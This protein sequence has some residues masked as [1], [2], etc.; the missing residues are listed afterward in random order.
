M[1]TIGD[2]ISHDFIE[3]GLNET[4]AEVQEKVGA[5]YGVV[6]D[7]DNRPVTIIVSADLANLD[8]ERPLAEGVGQVP[9]GIIAAITDTMEA[10]V[11]RPAFAAFALGVRGAI[12]YEDEQVAGV[13][14]DETITRY[15]QDE[16]EP[17]AEI[18]G[19]PADTRLGGNITDKPLIMYCD[20]F[21]HRNELDYYNRHKPP[22]C[23]VK[24]PNPHPIRRKK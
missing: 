5:G 21:N 3:L 12:V 8:G 6:R 18:K 9:P 20:E 4:V 22:E 11:Q 14:T 1:S 23:Q 15:L 10:F 7:A 17:V 19:F 16:F 2:R 24:E 13:L